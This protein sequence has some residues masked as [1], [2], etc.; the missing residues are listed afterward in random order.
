MFFCNF[1]SF[2]GRARG[3]F[4]TLL[5]AIDTYYK[6][7]ILQKIHTLSNTIQFHQRS[8]GVIHLV[9]AQNFPENLKFFSP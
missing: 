6:I 9:I 2:F 8:L 5:I 3:I 4:Q 7:A 1:G